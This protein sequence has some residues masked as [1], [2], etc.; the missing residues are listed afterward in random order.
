MEISFTY[1]IQIIRGAYQQFCT[2][3]IKFSIIYFTCYLSQLLQTLAIALITYKITCLYL[4][5]FTDF[6]F[7]ISDHLLL[8]MSNFKKNEWRAIIHFLQNEGLSP[9]EAAKKLKLY[10]GDSAPDRST[11]SRWIS[12]FTS[13][14]QSLEDDPR[15]GAPTTA[16][17]HTSILVLLKAY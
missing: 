16:K 11:A 14:R 15:S 7:L 5:I 17:T 4:L 2:M 13:G 3:A 9:T 6:F 10:Y 1:N 8:S 12:R